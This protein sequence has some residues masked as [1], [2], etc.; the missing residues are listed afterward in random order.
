MAN[1][2]YLFEFDLVID[3]KWQ[4]AIDAGPGFQVC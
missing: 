2:Q 1:D 4:L 3:C